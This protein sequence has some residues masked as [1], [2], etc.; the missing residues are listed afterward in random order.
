MRELRIRRQARH[1]LVSI[2]H[3]TLARYGGEPADAYLRGLAD[4]FDKLAE[5]PGIGVA[6]AELGQDLRSHVYRKHRV[7]YRVTSAMV[8]ILAVF[9]HAQIVR[10]ERLGD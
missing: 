2:R 7:Y 8:E 6:E 5:K 3:Y 1:D 10:T 9:H 4:L